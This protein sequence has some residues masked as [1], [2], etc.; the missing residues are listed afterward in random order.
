MLEVG[1]HGN[2]LLQRQVIMP[3]ELLSPCCTM[4][5][6]LG[7]DLA[8]QNDSVGVIHARCA[9]DPGHRDGPLSSVTVSTA[10][11]LSNKIF[12]NSPPRPA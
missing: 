4:F 9:D 12:H 2:D 10:Y 5:L 7:R 8:L 3:P 1:L 11:F 6:P